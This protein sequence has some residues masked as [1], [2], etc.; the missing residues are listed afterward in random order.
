M[1]LLVA[2]FVLVV[3]VVVVVDANSVAILGVLV[4]SG[5]AAGRGFSSSSTTATATAFLLGA[6]GLARRDLLFASLRRVG[7]RQ[8][9]VAAR[10]RISAAKKLMR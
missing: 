9:L 1:R 3:F 8:T 6:G 10:L 5:D 4:V 7:T 2:S